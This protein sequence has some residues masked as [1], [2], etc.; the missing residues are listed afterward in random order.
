M[1]NLDV[2][3]YTASVDPGE[4]YTFLPCQITGVY[5]ALLNLYLNQMFLSSLYPVYVGAGCI[6]KSVSGWDSSFFNLEWGGD[7]SKGKATVLPRNLTSA[8][9]SFMLLFLSLLLMWLE[10]QG[11]SLFTAKLIILAH[12]I[13]LPSILKDLERIWVIEQ[14]MKVFLKRNLIFPNMH[15]LNFLCSIFLN[16]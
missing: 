1:S 12:I 3:F 10:S 16:L 7:K 8:D 14:T 4:T 2:A 6:S 13:V 15:I 11:L 5:I 9:N